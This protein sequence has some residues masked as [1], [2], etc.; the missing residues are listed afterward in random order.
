MARNTEDEPKKSP[1]ELPSFCR[2]LSCLRDGDADIQ[3]TEAMHGLLHTLQ[4]RAED[5]SEAK[6]ELTLKLKVKVD[7]R[8]VVGITDDISVKEPN[9]GGGSSVFWLTE[10]GKL[11]PEN[12]RQQKLPLR[13]IPGE[14]RVAKDLPANDAGARSV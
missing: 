10:Q 14:T 12:P 7:N 6:G 3:L 13:G 5:T 8:G 4:E 11:T 1:T 2:I 9:P